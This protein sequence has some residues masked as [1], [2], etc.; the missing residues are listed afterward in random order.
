MCDVMP[1]ARIQK[2]TISE[3]ELDSR[4][5]LSRIQCGAGMTI[6]KKH[7]IYSYIDL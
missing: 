7:E 4:R 1:A 6:T 3:D 2:R 5:S